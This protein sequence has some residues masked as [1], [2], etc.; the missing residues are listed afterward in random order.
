MM[1]WPRSSSPSSR[2]CI[3][4]GTVALKYAAL[5]RNLPAALRFWSVL[6]AAAYLCSLLLLWTPAPTQAA[7][8]A[9]GS[10]APALSAD[11]LPG[12]EWLHHAPAAEIPVLDLEFSECGG[13][14]SAID[15]DSDVLL[16]R[17][18]YPHSVPRSVLASA[19]RAPA[20]HFA[21]VELRP[22]IV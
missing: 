10:P 16:P 6:T 14:S 15:D 8:S 19:S 4:I 21:A 5:V 13:C 7:A 11:L 18:H 1:A 3:T 9:A 20:L 17:F 12:A 2:Q 22:P